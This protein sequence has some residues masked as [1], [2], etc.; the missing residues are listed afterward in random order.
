MALANAKSPGEGG[1]VSGEGKK[2]VKLDP[3]V[4]EEVEEDRLIDSTLKETEIQ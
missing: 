1:E 4:E 2:R 3:E